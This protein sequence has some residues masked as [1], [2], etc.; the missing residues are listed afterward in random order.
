MTAPIY[1]LAGDLDLNIS[2]DVLHDLV[3]IRVH[4]RLLPGIAY[5]AVTVLPKS[6]AGDLAL[7]DHAVARVVDQLRPW[8]RPDPDPFPTIHPLPRL[9]AAIERLQQLRRKVRT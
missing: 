1:D 3:A 7:V 9:Q 6:A 2:D 8:T 4:Q 5:G